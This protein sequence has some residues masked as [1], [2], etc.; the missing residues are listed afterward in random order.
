MQGI[1]LLAILAMLVT[2][3]K[4]KV[5]ASFS[6][7]QIEPEK[8]TESFVPE[9]QTHDKLDILLV[10]DESGSMNTVH[11]TL[12]SRLEDL[13]VAVSDNDWQIAITTTNPLSCVLTVID[14]N[15]PNYKQIFTETINQKS[16]KDSYKDYSL[17][18]Y[19]TTEQA[20]YGAIRGLRGDCI[21]ARSLDSK[22]ANGL[23]QVAVNESRGG[24]S[25]SCQKKAT[26]VRDGSMLAVVLITDEDH[27]DKGKPQCRHHHGCHITDFYFYLKS[28]R[29]PH[30]TGRVYGL[31]NDK[32]NK[33]FLSWQD[34]S[35]E[36][37][38][39]YHDSINSPDYTKILTK[40]SQN[41]AAALK[42]N[43]T[44]QHEHDGDSAKVVITTE[45]GETKTLDAGQ[46]SVAGN[47]LSLSITLPA[48]T[49][50]IEVTYT[51]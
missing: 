46:Y 41:I 51:H 4:N 2:C 38:F 25:S 47:S 26:W 21:T 22:D 5:G 31:L 27:I 17:Y 23:S 43:F 50:K 16:L 14:K 37:L 7:N 30:A 1:K 12:A 45:D 20:I 33:I 18:D 3:N 13:L 44:L 29:T 42:H 34:D 39:D 6:S 28:I 9:K 15:T 32:E 35:G 36:S 11:T 49:T 40:I 10:I 19:A 48:N 24:Y 8:S